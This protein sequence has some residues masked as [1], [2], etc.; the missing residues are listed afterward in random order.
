[1]SVAPAAVL[2]NCLTRAALIV[3]PVEEAE[4]YRPARDIAVA[5]ASEVTPYINELVPSIGVTNVVVYVDDVVALKTII[6]SLKAL[7]SRG[8]VSDE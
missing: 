7:R 6:T 8:I 4:T 3:T 5:E 1:M 2:E